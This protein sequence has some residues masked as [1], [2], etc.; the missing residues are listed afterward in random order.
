MA[1]LRPLRRRS[2]RAAGRG[3]RSPCRAPRGASGR[4]AEAEVLADDRRDVA[5]GPLLALACGLRAAADEQERPER[6]APLQR[7]V[8]AAA[9]VGD[10]APVDGLV[11]EGERDDEVAGVG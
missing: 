7:P 11:A 9:G 6:V 4:G 5:Q 3:A 8:A 2:G 1:A 10:A